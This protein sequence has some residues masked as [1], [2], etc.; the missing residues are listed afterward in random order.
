MYRPRV[1]TRLILCPS[2]IAAAYSLALYCKNAHNSFSFSA[3]LVIFI[4][5]SYLFTKKKKNVL[6]Q[7]A[8]AFLSTTR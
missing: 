4:L 8:S 3:Y 5:F 2:Y 7:L 1:K 6:W